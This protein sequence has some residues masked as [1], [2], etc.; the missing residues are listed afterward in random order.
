[1]HA[2]RVNYVVVIYY[3]SYGYSLICGSRDREFLTLQVAQIRMCRKGKVNWGRE[4]P[5]FGY[6]LVI[7]MTQAQSS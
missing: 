2:N 7:P 1:M 6:G 3:M 5:Y 4:G